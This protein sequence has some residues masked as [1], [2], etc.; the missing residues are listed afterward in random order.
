MNE[1]DQPT[2][3]STGIQPIPVNQRIPKRWVEA[4]RKYGHMQNQR[5]NETVEG[6]FM[7][8]LY[9]VKQLLNGQHLTAFSRNYRRCNAYNAFTMEVFICSSVYLHLECSM[10]YVYRVDY[11]FNNCQHEV[12]VRKLLNVYVLKS[13]AR[14]VQLTPS[15]GQFYQAVLIVQDSKHIILL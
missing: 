14:E 9:Q 8:I 4:K 3:K 13:R 11:A 7:H 12:E 15:F 10:D 1:K 5:D 2:G 6:Q